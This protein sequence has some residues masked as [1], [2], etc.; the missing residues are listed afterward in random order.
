M[1]H[2]LLQKFQELRCVNIIVNNYGLNYNMFDANKFV[3]SQ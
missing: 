3:W 2:M 1:M